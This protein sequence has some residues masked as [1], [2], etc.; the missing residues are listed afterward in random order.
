M[1]IDTQ[2]TA[3]RKV[4]IGLHNFE[5]QIFYINILLNIAPTYPR[6]YFNSFMVW[7]KV[8]YF[9]Q[10][11][12]IDVNSLRACK[13]SAHTESSTSNRN[14]VVIFNN[15]LQLFYCA[16]CFNFGNNNRIELSNII[17]NSFVCFKCGINCAAPFFKIVGSKFWISTIFIFSCSFF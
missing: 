10:T 17:Y 7:R 6:F 12:H 16:W 11:A 1:A 2:G 15:I 4:C 13:F 3:Y 9:I 5:T 14:S 8:D